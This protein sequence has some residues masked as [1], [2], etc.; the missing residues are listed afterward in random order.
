MKFKETK[1]IKNFDYPVACLDMSISESGNF[2]ASIGT[3][4]PSVKIHDLIN[5]AQKSN[6]HLEAE[7]LKIISIDKNCEKLALLRVDRYVEFHVKYGM[8]EKIRMPKMCYDLKLNKFNGE[9]LACGKSS[10]IFRFDLIGG[11]FNNS[12]NTSLEVVMSAD[13]NT[14]H[15]LIGYC[16]N[17]MIEFIDQR[18]PCIVSSMK[19]KDN[20]LQ[21]AFSENGI[22]FSTGSYDGTVKLFDLR[23]TNEL[24]SYKHEKEVRKVKMVGK[25]II[26]IDQNELCVYSNGTIFDKIHFSVPINT[27]DVDGGV[28]FL[29]MDDK[30]M[31]TI[32][33]TD[34]GEIPEWCHV[35][36]VDENL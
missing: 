19:Y 31:K 17:N 28:I 7:P 24:S 21:F 23:S 3:Y 29:G 10:E 36:K 15:G 5:I 4:K 32:Y 14:K 6:R 30:V 18:D 11:K 22:N 9:L 20:F 16:G 12:Y 35:I 8:H 2:L 34:F 27:F 13:I 1:I 26:S 25:S 33:C